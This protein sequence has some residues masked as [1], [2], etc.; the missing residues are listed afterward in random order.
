MVFLGD[1]KI[2]NLL[3]SYA[4][5]ELDFSKKCLHNWQKMWV[6]LYLC[7]FLYSLVRRI[8]AQESCEPDFLEKCI[9]MGKA[10]FDHPEN[11]FPANATDIERVCR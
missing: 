2:Y 11:I 10:L 7:V 6:L 1:L 5:F 8:A 3:I 4:N 9:T